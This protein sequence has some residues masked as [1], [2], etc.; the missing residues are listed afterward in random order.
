MDTLLEIKNI[1]YW[2]KSRAKYDHWGTGK[3]GG[4]DPDS[5]AAWWFQTVTTA[6]EDI[7]KLIGE[8]EKLEVQLQEK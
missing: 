7:D 5:G 3:I 4:V 8:I 1:G 2:L 6:Q